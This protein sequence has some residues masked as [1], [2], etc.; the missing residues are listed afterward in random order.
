MIKQ[1]EEGEKNV[2][3]NDKCSCSFIKRSKKM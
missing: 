2:E 3:V 1:Y